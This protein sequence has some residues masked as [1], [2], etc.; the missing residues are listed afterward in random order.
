MGRIKKQTR[1]IG[2]DMRGLRSALQKLI[3]DEGIVGSH[4]NFQQCL[5][6][7]YSALQ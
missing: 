4:L 2:R 7:F 1:S 3:H 5:D 6:L